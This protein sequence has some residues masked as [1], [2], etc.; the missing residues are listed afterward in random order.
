M[1]GL[2]LPAVSTY[3]PLEGGEGSLD[4]MG[5]AAMSDR[6]A[7]LLVPGL[8]AR[9]RSARFVTA[10][11]VGSLACEPLAD[12]TP[13]DGVSTPAICFEWLVLEAF[14]RRIGNAMP[15]GVPGSLKTRNILVQGGR[16]SAATY[17]KS[18]GVFGF[19][20]VYKPFAIESRVVEPGLEPGPRAAEVVRA[21]EADQG[22]DG[23]VDQVPGSDGDR[24]RQWIHDEVDRALR[25]GRCVTSSGSHVFG[26]LAR[27]LHPGAAGRNERRALRSLLTGPSAQHTRAE[28]ARL[29]LTV[30]GQ[31]SD[32]AYLLA[33][34]RPQCSPELGALVD[35]V[36]A[37]EQL[38][39]MIDAAFR[40][41]CTISY[42]IGD[43]PMTVMLARE[44]PTLLRC[45]AEVPALYRTAVERIG[46]VAPARELEERLGE[47]AIRRTAGELVELLLDHHQRTQQRKPPNG[48][49]PWFEPYRDGWV[50]R[51]AYGAAEPPEIDGQ[52][53]H[54]VR[55]DTLHRFMKETG[56][57]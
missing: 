2:V 12:R 51:L 39:A 56:D 23:F 7:D 25:E 33:A 49:L 1:N 50:V 8:R 37:Y 53:I 24:L 31:G 30:A 35:A 13:A 38:A 16:L 26:E 47:F 27:T 17:L 40:T 10:M 22:L 44:S 41:L 29:L 15:T 48:K 4:P 19:N 9:M 5:L 42:S 32:E 3:D 57:E 45:A 43:Q 11:A 52:F 34:V 14:V 36:V 54:P 21:W 46:P 6:L 20:G 28:L 18:P 55:V